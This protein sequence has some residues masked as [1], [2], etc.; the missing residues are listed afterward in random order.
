ML[1]IDHGANIYG[2]YKD[3]MNLLHLLFL[4]KSTRLVKVEEHRHELAEILIEKGIDVHQTDKYGATPMHYAAMN[5]HEDIVGMLIRASS[6]PFDEKTAIGNSALHIA[7][8]KGLY[9]ITCRLLE[10]DKVDVDILD[11]ELKTPLHCTAITGN[12]KLARVL[13][14]HG[15]NIDAVTVNGDTPL[16]LACAHSNNEF[17]EYLVENGCNTE[18]KNKL[19]KTADFEKFITH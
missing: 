2:S 16:H 15:A 5:E 12:V 19:E 4:S 14:T 10:N 6:E 1:L 8:W 13:V 18:I 9:K 17:V 11:P 7:S 3:K